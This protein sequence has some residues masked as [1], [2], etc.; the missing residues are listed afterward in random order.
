MSIWWWVAS[1]VV[2]FSLVGYICLLFSKRTCMLAFGKGVSDAGRLTWGEIEQVYSSYL[3]PMRPMD[4]AAY[5][6]GLEYSLNC[7]NESD[8][9]DIKRDFMDAWKSGAI[10][11]EG[12]AIRKAGADSAIL[13]MR[14]SRELE[15]LI[16]RNP[17]YP[18]LAVKAGVLSERAVAS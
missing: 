5:Q 14:I 16:K 9:Q 2:G 6:R 1:V 8:W 15:E 12:T 7:G 17:D 13:R 10:T 11:R 4:A 3:R 18:P